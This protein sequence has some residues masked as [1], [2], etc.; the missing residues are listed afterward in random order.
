MPRRPDAEEPI[1]TPVQT[2]GKATQ[3]QRLHMGMIAAA[4]RDGYA[5][6]SVTAVIARGGRLAPDVL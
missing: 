4:N 1:N 3:L 5:G 2:R 6:A